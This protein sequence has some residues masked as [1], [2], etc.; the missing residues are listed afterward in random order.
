MYRCRDVRKVV[1]R[2]AGSSVNVCTVF[3][4]ERGVVRLQTRQFRFDL[5]MQVFEKVLKSD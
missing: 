2:S 4:A 1:S 5:L 3:A